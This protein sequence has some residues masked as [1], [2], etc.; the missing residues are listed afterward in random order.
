MKEDA[1]NESLE[2]GMS[3]MTEEH[4]GVSQ[5]ETPEVVGSM[6]GTK[7]SLQVGPVE[8]SPRGVS[9]R[10]REVVNKAVGKT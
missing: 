9:W 8:D 1:S 6:S 5:E 7:L 3:R 2:L 10:S 4:C